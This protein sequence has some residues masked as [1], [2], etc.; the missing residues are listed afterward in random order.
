MARF[1]NTA[2]RSLLALMTLSCCLSAANAETY[3]VRAGDTLD[4][5]AKRQGT[6]VATLRALNPRIGDPRFLQAGQVI[7]VKSLPKQASVASIPAAPKSYTVR[8][9]DTLTRIA[10]R[11][12]LN[13]EALRAANPALRAPYTLKVGQVVNLPTSNRVAASGAGKVNTVSTASTNWLWPL[14]GPITSGFGYREFTVF[15]NHVHEGVDIAATP[16][17]PIRAARGGTVVEARF[18]MRNGW[19]GTVVLDHG[20]GW[21]SRYSHASALLVQPGQAVAPGQ[22]I[23]RV[24]STG[25]STGPHLDF[26]IFYQGK[27][28]DPTT[29]R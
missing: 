29:F 23:A 24:G 25:I 1:S 3:R 7:T 12:G 20:N 16:G 18:D 10:S 9:G 22:V 28:L 19:G 2:R 6:T 11:N 4:S 27:A 5:I 14:Q 17:S 8:A 13:L 26:R 15:G 21:T